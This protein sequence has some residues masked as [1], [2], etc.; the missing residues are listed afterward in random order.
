M[1]ARPRIAIPSAHATPQTSENRAIALY[2]KTPEERY[3]N[4]INYDTQLFQ[5]FS[6]KVTASLLKGTLTQP[7]TQYKHRQTVA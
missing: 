1:K 2:T 3:A 4:L 5:H 6:L 7:Y